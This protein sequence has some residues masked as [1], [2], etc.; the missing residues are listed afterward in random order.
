MSTS[1]DSKESIALFSI[2]EVMFKLNIA[3]ETYETSNEG[4]EVCLIRKRDVETMVINLSET[5]DRANEI[6]HAWMHLLNS[7]STARY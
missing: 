7:N 5:I 6:L 4:E 1:G 3:Q 2:L